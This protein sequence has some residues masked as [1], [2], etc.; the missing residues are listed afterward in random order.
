[1]SKVESLLHGSRSWL[2]SCDA[3][4]DVVILQTAHK[5]LCSKHICVVLDF[6]REGLLVEMINTGHLVGLGHH[7]QSRILHCLHSLRYISP[8]RCRSAVK[9]PSP[10][11]RM[12]PPVP[13]AYYFSCRSYPTHSCSACGRTRMDP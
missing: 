6:Q 1:M 4:T 12:I 5:L 9:S 11:P 7:P 13:S 10:V 2:L 3:M 8:M